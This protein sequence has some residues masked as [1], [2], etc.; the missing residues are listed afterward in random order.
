MICRYNGF[1][2]DVRALELRGGI[3]WIFQLDVER[4]DGSGV[5]VWPIYLRKIFV[6]SS[7]A[8]KAA[9]ICARRSIDSGLSGLTAI[10]E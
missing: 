10:N 6:T 7:D 9:L 3:G 1:F 2:I 4:H 8:I 5:T